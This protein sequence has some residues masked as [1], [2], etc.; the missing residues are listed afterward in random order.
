MAKPGIRIPDN[1]HIMRILSATFISFLLLTTHNTSLA[2]LKGDPDI[3]CF[4]MEN[5]Q[6]VEITNPLTS[7]S[8]AMIEQIEA[9]PNGSLHLI[10]DSRWTSG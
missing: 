5:Q 6:V 2:H 4:K 8:F 9:V 1:I 7:T 10:L 3:P